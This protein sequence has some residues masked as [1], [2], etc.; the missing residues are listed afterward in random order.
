MTLSLSLPPLSLS[1]THTHTNKPDALQPHPRTSS[2]Q[3][4]HGDAPP[5]PGVRHRKWGQVAGGQMDCHSLA[6]PDR[7][8]F[9]R[10]PV[11]WPAHRITVYRSLFCARYALH[12]LCFQGSPPFKTHFAKLV[13]SVPG[14][15]WNKRPLSSHTNRQTT[16]T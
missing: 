6:S 3:E 14:N 2:L 5:L 8:Y 1:H 7:Q 16:A 12:G 10:S 11:V 4:E 15:A 9:S 13:L